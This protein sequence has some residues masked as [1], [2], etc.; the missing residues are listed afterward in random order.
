VI[1][2]DLSPEQTF[3]TVFQ[4]GLPLSL[5]PNVCDHPRGDAAEYKRHRPC[6][7]FVDHFGSP[8]FTIV[9]DC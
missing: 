8:F 3:H 5:H 1:S 4:R 2:D 7:D 9:F 6:Y